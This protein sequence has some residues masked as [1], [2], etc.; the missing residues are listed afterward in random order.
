MLRDDSV[1]T[2]G[3]GLIVASRVVGYIYAEFND[4]FHKTRIE[5]SRLM[6]IN[7]S[8]KNPLF[9]GTIIFDDKIVNSRDAINLTVSKVKEYLGYTL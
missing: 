5:M 3:T 2:S 7:W 9:K 6:Y 4:D 8:R 1:I